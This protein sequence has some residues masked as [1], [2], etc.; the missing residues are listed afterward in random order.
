MPPAE[1]NANRDGA[2]IFLPPI[3]DNN[4]P[5]ST[6]TSSE[7][8]VPRRWMVVSLLQNDSKC[9]FSFD[10]IQCFP[11]KTATGSF[12]WIQSNANLCASSLMRAH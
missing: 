9:V 5:S 12:C 7:E 6:L 2:D 11:T 1:Y 3:K 10:E 4:F 8:N